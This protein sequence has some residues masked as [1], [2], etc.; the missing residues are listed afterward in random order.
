MH[1][2]HPLIARLAAASTLQLD[3]WRDQAVLAYLAG[4]GER[5]IKVSADD[6]PLPDDATQE[7]SAWSATFDCATHTTWQLCSSFQRYSNH[8]PAE[9]FAKSLSTCGKSDWRVAEIEELES[10]RELANFPAVPNPKYFPSVNDEWHWS[11]SP[12]PE[13]AGY[14]RYVSFGGGGS[15]V[16]HRDYAYHVLAC[17]GGLGAV[18]GVSPGQ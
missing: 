9:K 8:G 10:I 2:V 16:N 5:Y 3:D 4:T 17:R 7:T 18:G 11:S 13:S 1:K 12:D 15:D 6:Q 14:A